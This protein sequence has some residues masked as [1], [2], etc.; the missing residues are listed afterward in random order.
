MEIGPGVFVSNVAAGDWE[1]DPEVGG[2]LHLLCAEGGVEAGLSRFTETTEPVTW[3][4][5]APETLLVDD[6]ASHH[7]VQGVL[8]DAAVSRRREPSPA[9][10]PLR[11]SPDLV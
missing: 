10:A 3:T 5:P 6:V 9:P 4:I 8:D 2:E 7:A 11:P 1:A